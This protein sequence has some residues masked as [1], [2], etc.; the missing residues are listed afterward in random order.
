MHALRHFCKLCPILCKHR[1]VNFGNETYNALS[2][3]ACCA[4]VGDRFLCKA[5]HIG[6]T[7]T[8]DICCRYIGKNLLSIL[9]NLHFIS[10][11][12]TSPPLPK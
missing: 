11:G 7:V 4:N 8:D 1:Y 10:P 5:Q 2:V 6:I 9:H 3:S 12:C